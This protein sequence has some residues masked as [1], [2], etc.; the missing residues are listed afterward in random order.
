MAETTKRDMDLGIVFAPHS[1]HYSRTSFQRHYE[2]FHA[3]LFF[4][5]AHPAVGRYARNHI[6]GVLGAD[7]HFD[8]ISEFGIFP[9]KRADL[10]RILRSPE[11]K[12]LE[13]DVQTFLAERGNNFAITERHI[14]GPARQCKPGPTRKC[15]ILMQK[16]GNAS[17]AGIE[18]AATAYAQDMARQ[19]GTAAE[20]IVLMLW[21]P[22]PP[23]PM[24][25]MLMIW[26]S[27]GAALPS[28]ASPPDP[29]TIAYALDVD[30]YC[31]TWRD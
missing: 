26:P 18:S 7:P 5:H 11:A 20:R 29:L 4:S 24:D 14:S 30:E 6:V 3:P 27:A 19:L 1:E 28:P 15:A 16:T 22:S 8:T 10:T 9:E 25:A 31:T 23:P 2:D 13:D 17:T 12:S 21:K